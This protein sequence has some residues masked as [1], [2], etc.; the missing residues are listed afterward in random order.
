MAGLEPARPYELRILSPLRLPFRHTGSQNENAKGIKPLRPSRKVRAA[1]RK[2]KR[3]F[4]F[5][6]NASSL[7][8]SHH[9][10]QRLLGLGIA[11]VLCLLGALHLR[12][13]GD[14]PWHRVP[15]GLQTRELHRTSR[16]LSVSIRA[17]RAPASSFRVAGN[18]YLT[19]ANWLRQTRARVV[20]N[21]GYFDGQGRPMGF[22]AGKNT[23]P[24]KLRRADWGVFWVKNGVAHV[25]HTRDFSSSIHP[26]EAVQCGPRLVVNGQPTQLK[27]QWARRTGVGIDRTGLVVLAVS[28]GEVSLDEWAKIWASPSGLNC[29]DALNMDGGPSTQLA[30]QGDEKLNVEGGWPVP[31]VLAFK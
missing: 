21:A 30:A 25:S 5:V 28:D 2:I 31:D 16:A 23:P 20:V 27:P 29:R 8:S 4:R 18:H 3:H 9:T 12:A 6:G 22:R 1:A 17:F 11:G 14:S 19:A 24:S 10:M 13:H 7:L 15:S 26:D